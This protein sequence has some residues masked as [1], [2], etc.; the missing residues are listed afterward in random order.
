VPHIL[1]LPV[2]SGSSR[3]TR[4]EAARKLGVGSRELAV[5]SWELGVEI[6]G[7]IRVGQEA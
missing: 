2:A 7:I 1:V 6:A 5:G 3:K 4:G